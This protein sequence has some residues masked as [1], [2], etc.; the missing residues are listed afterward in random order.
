VAN[1]DVTVVVGGG[2]AG[3]LTATQLLD[4]GDGEVVI[5]EPR[6]RLGTGVAYGAAAPWHLLNSP[7]SAMSAD[8]TRPTD[9]LDWLHARGIPAQPGDFLPRR[10]YGDYLQ[11]TMDA[12]AAR[13]GDR[14]R[15]LP[16]QVRRLVPTDDGFVVQ[17]DDGAS[18][19]ATRVVLAVGS[20]RSSGPAA[21][22]KLAHHPGWLPDP[23][24]A[25]AMESV[26]AD[27]PVLLVGTGLTAV[28]VALSLAR[29]ERTTPLLAVSRHGLVPQSHRTGAAASSSHH[30]VPPR[31]GL[32][33]LVRSV[34][35]AAAHTGDWRGVVDGLRPQLDSLWRSLP[36]RGQAAFLEHCARLWETHRHRMAPAI[37]QQWNGLCTNGEL[38]IRADTIASVTADDDRLSV[39][40]RSGRTAEVGAIINCTGPGRLPASAPSVIAALL[41]DG[42]ATVGP[43][44][45]G[46]DVDDAG[47]IVGADGHATERLWAVG[48]LRRG[49]FWET[50]AAPEIR[51]Q[52]ARLAS[53]I[54]A[55]SMAVDSAPDPIA[56]SWP[57]E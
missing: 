53:V 35:A 37:A 39:S 23:W 48:P 25:G 51:D 31:V 40:F 38:A 44:G 33:A 55:P 49:R 15:V 14:L 24:A 57:P 1:R 21:L 20:P 30:N 43:F 4:H 52:A 54:A 9:F 13:Y 18:L 32:P 3:A 16:G 46:L 45:L 26:P 41:S 34:R 29:T 28:D 5:V 11:S 19:A 8:P 36:V 12:A 27:A 2:C 7:A 10:S 6:S 22:G 50:T 56:V 47:R 42:L 17:C